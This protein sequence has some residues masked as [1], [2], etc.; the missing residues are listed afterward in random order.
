MKRIFITLLFLFGFIFSSNSF[1]DSAT[2]AG[3]M[4]TI[5]EI[6]NS[7]AGYGVFGTDVAKERIAYYN[8]Q[9]YLY[10]KD[11]NAVMTGS[12]AWV[13]NELWTVISKRLFTLKDQ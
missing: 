9:V 2:G 5:T 10:G 11:L 1:A 8:D 13:R 4:N 6:M 12:E 3:T 7:M